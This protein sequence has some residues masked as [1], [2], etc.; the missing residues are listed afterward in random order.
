MPVLT[1]SDLNV[2]FALHQS[3]VTAVS[4]LSFSLEPGETLAYQY[5][6]S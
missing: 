6:N 2:R 5:I 1:V 4:D 3:E